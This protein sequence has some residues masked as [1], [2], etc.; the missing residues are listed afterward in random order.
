MVIGYIVLVYLLIEFG[1]GVL[2][3][4]RG[5]AVIDTAATGASIGFRLLI[6]PASIL[7]WPLLMQRWMAA[8]RPS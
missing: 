6:L 4:V 1:F 3:V 2:F 5:A 8:S 7:L